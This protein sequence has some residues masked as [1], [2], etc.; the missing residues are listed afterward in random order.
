M[1]GSQRWIQ[2][3]V[4]L[5]EMHLKSLGVGNTSRTYNR[6]CL[7][8]FGSRGRFLNARFLLVDG[9]IFFPESKFVMAR[10]QLRRNGDVADGYEAINFTVAHA[11]FRNES[12]IAK[13][14]II[15]TNMGRSSLALAT[16][17]TR[18]SIQELLKSK[19][20]TL[21][22]VVEADFNVRMNATNT[23][24]AVGLNGN[25]TATLIKPNGDFE[26]AHGEVIYDSNQGKTIYDYVI[27][28][29]NSGGSSWSIEE[30]NNEDLHA[31]NS[32]MKAF[33]ASHG[34]VGRD[35]IAVCEKCTCLAIESSIDDCESLLCEVPADQEKCRC[36]VDNTPPEVSGI[37]CTL[38]LI[39]HFHSVLCTLNIQNHT[40]Y[41][42]VIVLPVQCVKFINPTPVVPPVTSVLAPTAPT[43]TPCK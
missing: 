22:A 16:S 38:L 32:S 34:I 12:H 8:Q 3:F 6:Y 35:T 2:I 37:N 14:L 7:V 28:S 4:P 33:V 40:N 17:L 21:D 18:E 10:R 9:R 29:L 15:A 13:H 41:H 39:F 11:P 31:L 36:T 42:V 30:F 43:E 1:S 19:N 5:L 26:F 23:V 20:I 25:E 24:K 27:L